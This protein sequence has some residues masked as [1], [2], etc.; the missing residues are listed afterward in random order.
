MTELE[1]ELL[2]ALVK[3]NWHLADLYTGKEFSDNFRE[4]VLEPLIAKAYAVAETRAKA[5]K[6]GQG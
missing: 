4:K 2:T 3:A 6:E 5:R 1:N